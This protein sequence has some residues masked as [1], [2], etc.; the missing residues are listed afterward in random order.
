MLSEKLNKVL[1]EQ[2]VYEYYSAYLYL[3]MSAS[4]DNLGL[5]GVSKWLSVQSQEELAH[6]THMYKYI[7]ERG[8]EPHFSAI[9]KPTV[10][11]SNVKDI[12]KQA[13]SHEQSITQKI[14]AIATLALKEHDHACYEFITWYVKE[15]VEEEDN[16]KKILGKLKHIEAGQGS[17]LD[18]DN[19]L[20][21]RV[22]VDPFPQ[23]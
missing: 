19:E 4:A 10:G 23:K 16:A 20:A 8:S 11:F 1:S 7:L 21:T 2:F 3:S 15:Q 6:G 5:E 17:L 9:E 22:F 12:F 18:L 13:L 14:N